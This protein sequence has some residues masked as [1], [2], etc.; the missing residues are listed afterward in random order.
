MQLSDC[1]AGDIEEDVQ[2]SVSG[3]LKW[4]GTNTTGIQ[5]GDVDL[6]GGF[7]KG[8]VPV[9]YSQRVRGGVLRNFKTRI[10]RGWRQRAYEGQEKNCLD[11]RTAVRDARPCLLPSLSLSGA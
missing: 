7:K 5:T 8:R 4:R 6:L 10:A 2:E 9:R 3:G 11:G 1:A